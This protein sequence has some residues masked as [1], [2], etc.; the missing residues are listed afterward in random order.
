MQTITRAK[1]CQNC[2]F[3][4]FNKRNSDFYGG[5]KKINGLC[6]RYADAPMPLHFDSQDYVGWT[7]EG[8]RVTQ[9]FKDARSGAEL[10]SWPEFRSAVLSNPR[11]CVPNRP[12][13]P[14]IG[15]WYTGCVMWSAWWIR[16]WQRVAER[17]IDRT[18]V[19]EAWDG[20][21]TSKF[22]RAKKRKK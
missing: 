3:S 11:Y 15:D 13:D 5:G 2:R 6:M 1:T 8:Q 7:E 12:S 21:Q 20:T 4:L 14:F 18:T 10:P 17:H 16:N 22:Y 9:A 19:C